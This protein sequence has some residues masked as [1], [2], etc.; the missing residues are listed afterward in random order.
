MLDAKDSW[1]L[2]SPLKHKV[3]LGQFLR[4]KYI[5]TLP[6]SIQIFFWS[7]LDGA[8]WGK[9]GIFNIISMVNMK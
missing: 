7:S 2:I 6:S 5:R 4:Q 3:P 1:N 9:D 8:F